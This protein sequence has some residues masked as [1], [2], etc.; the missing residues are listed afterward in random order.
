MIRWDLWDRAPIKKEDFFSIVTQINNYLCVCFH[1]FIDKGVEISHHDYPLKSVSPIPNGEGASF[2][3]SIPLSKNKRAI[4][5]SYILQHP[6][7]WDDDYENSIHF[8]SFSLLDGFERQQGIY[9][10]RC[11]RL[12]TPK[13]GWLS[14][15]K[16]EMR[17]NLQE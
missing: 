12:L 13:G 8:N 17:Q 15:L 10:Y 2:H 1:R 11:D 9:I 6:K 16:K 4:Q 7:N 3:S 14:L 5:T